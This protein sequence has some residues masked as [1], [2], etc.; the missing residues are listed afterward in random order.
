SLAA[1][2]LHQ[3]SCFLPFAEIICSLS[4]VNEEL[5]SR[6]VF[7]TPSA[8]PWWMFLFWLRLCRAV[9]KVLH[10]FHCC[11]TISSW[12][13]MQ[14]RL[15]GTAVNRFALMSWPQCRHSPNVPL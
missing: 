15:H 4:F 7:F 2:A 5:N 11:S 12:Q 14:Y 8:P 13:V 6:L 10:P 1:A 3:T 9:V